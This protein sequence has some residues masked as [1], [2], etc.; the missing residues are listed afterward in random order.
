M[1]P[2]IAHRFDPVAP[3]RAT[4]PTHLDEFRYWRFCAW[5][6]YVFMLV[7]VVCWGLLSG[8]CPPFSADLP[9]SDIAAFFREQQNWI[10]AGM[11]ISMTFAICYLI[12]AVAIGRVMGKV[13]G[14]DSVLVDL[15]V[16]GAGLTVVPILIAMSFW[17]TAAF[18]P[19]G[20]PDAVLQMLYDMAWLLIDLAYATTSVQMIAIGVAFLNDPREEPLV[21]KLLAWYGIWVGFAFAAECLMPFFK[22][23]AFARNGLLNF[24]VE[25]PIWFLWAPTLTYYILKAISRLEQEAEAAAGRA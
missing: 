22:A 7:F 20:L 13:V 5:N 6:G 9:A 12:W 15:Q 18:R 16:W 19:E 1:S 8:N 2:Q 11:V 21:P 10:R 25:F 23:G 3:R 24:W 4:T 14:K 17:L